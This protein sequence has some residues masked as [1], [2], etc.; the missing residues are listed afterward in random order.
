FLRG[1]LLR[2]A[3]LFAEGPAARRGL[4]APGAMPVLG[5]A[6]VAVASTGERR[7]EPA[8]RPALLAGRP[9]PAD[10]RGPAAER[11]PALLP[12]LPLAWGWPLAKPPVTLSERG[13]ATVGLLGRAPMPKG[14]EG[15]LVPILR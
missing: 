15:W 9:R 5:V 8:P 1:A 12:P 13:A 3:A 4:L 2:G 6:S 14:S 10:L 11:G 7:A